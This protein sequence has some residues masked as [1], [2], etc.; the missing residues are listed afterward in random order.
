MAHK[1]GTA[2][3][4]GLSEITIWKFLGFERKKVYFPN[5][6]FTFIIFLLSLYAAQS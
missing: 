1:L 2:V 5:K 3:L 6:K 4:D